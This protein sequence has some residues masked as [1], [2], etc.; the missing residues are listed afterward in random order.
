MNVLEKRT[1][2]NTGGSGTFRHLRARSKCPNPA[3]ADYSPPLAE[4]GIPFVKPEL[5]GVEELVLNR[6][7]VAEAG[8]SN[9]LIVTGTKI[10]SVRLS[11]CRSFVT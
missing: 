3:D 1:L 9:V 5:F 10:L 4:R 2:E 7:L 8:I 6:F 11:L